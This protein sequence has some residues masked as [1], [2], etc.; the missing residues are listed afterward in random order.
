MPDSVGELRG[1]VQVFLSTYGEGGYKLAKRVVAEEHRLPES[2]RAVLSYFL[3]EN[4]RN[5]QHPALIAAACR[6]VGG[7][8]KATES[9]AASIVLLT[10]AAD[11]HD[12]IIDKSKTKT[13]KPTAYGKFGQ[14]AA[15]LAGDALLFLGLMQFNKAIEEFSVE[16]RQ[17]LRD[18][19]ERA[20][21]K[22]GN[23][24]VNESAFKGKCAVKPQAYLSVLE[25]KGSVAEA[26][27]QMGAIIGDGASNDVN[28]LAQVGKTLGLLMTIRNEF[29]DLQYPQEL[30]MRVKGETLPLPVLY[31]LEDRK[32][33]A[34]VLNLLKGRLTVDVARLVA[35]VVAGSVGVAGLKADMAARAHA[36]DVLLGRLHGNVEPFRLLLKLAVTDI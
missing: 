30:K 22:I 27:V 28:I 8:F 35:E 11:M 21:L 36:A 16:K 6:A 4:W 5:T 18:L 24:V 7:N 20:F 23:V 29:A 13:Y 32:I 9:V 2:V 14:E 31:A 10:G 12:D 1:H 17:K 34:K 19:I 15:L 25:A 3:E 33:K 26:C